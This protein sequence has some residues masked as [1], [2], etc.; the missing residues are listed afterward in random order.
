MQQWTIDDLIDHW[1]LLP[2]ER[3]QL[4]NKT[5]ATRLGF[6]VML[7]AFALEGRF[8]S[9]IHD[10]APAVVAYLAKQV[11]IAPDLYQHY[12]WRGRSSSNHR[13]QIRAFY[14]FR[15]CS[16]DDLTRMTAWL[17]ADVL[18]A[19]Q[20]PAILRAH[21]LQQLRELHIEPP[22]PRQIDKVIASA[23]NTYE[24]RFCD[25][26]LR[27][28]TQAGLARLDALLK[29]AVPMDAGI[30]S[31]DDVEQSPRLV[32]RVSPFHEL[33]T[34]SGRAGLASILEHIAKLQRIRALDLPADL[35]AGVSPHLIQAYRSRAA[36]ESPSEL[37]AHP[38]PIRAT[39]LS[40]FCT[41]RN[42][43]LTDTLVELLIQTIHKINVKAERKVDTQILQEFRRVESKTGI[44]FRLAE[45]AVE[46]PDGIVREVLFPVVGEQTLQDLL[47]EYKATNV[48]YKRKVHTVVRNSYRAHYRRMVPILVEAFDFRS[49]NAIHRPVT[50]ALAL[51]KKYVG[52]TIRCYPDDEV[53]PIDG[54]ISATMQPIIV[55]I[56]TDGHERI[57]RM[58]YE[59]CVLQA[60]RDGLRSREIW[61]PGATKYRNP[62]EDLPKD[63]EQ[64]RST[65]YTALKQPEDADVFLT[66][67]QQQVRA[68][69]RLFHDGLPQNA[70]V[71]I[72]TKQALNQDS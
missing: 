37:Q 31:E 29:P 4:A 14:A 6:A 22:K 34:G 13:A 18:D 56:D 62:D 32:V 64:H 48:A 30:L 57:N 24:I 45:A 26:T 21:V 49:N 2:S 53:V 17:C 43:E 5:G 58:S 52:S 39:L 10:I 9:T 16:S 68:A 15:E 28:V 41:L 42:G 61:V 55:E 50:Q 12:D 8:P 60:L 54:V 36:T 35:F 40:A 59:I 3:E 67:L 51:L 1:T 7:K 70:K 19:E 71:R 72:L 65:Y 69:L 63:F 38:D 27:H 33:R 44:L 20:R 46:N 66:T 25:T 11:D 23:L 47:K